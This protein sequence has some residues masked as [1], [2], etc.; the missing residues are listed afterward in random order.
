MNDANARIG[1]IGNVTLLPPTNS[2]DK[3]SKSYTCNRSFQKLTIASV[4]FDTGPG[5][6]LMDWYASKITNNALQY[7]ID[8]KLAAQ[9]KV[10]EKLLQI[11]LT[12]PYFA[13]KPPKTTGRELFTFKVRAIEDF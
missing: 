5:N 6:V 11:M 3:P 4:G 8:G 13:A 2:K 12:H 9:G 7:D 10:N 1:G